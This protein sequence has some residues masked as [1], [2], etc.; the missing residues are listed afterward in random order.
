MTI[1]SWNI[2]RV[3]FTVA[4]T[5]ALQSQTSRADENG[6]SLWLPGQFGSLAA[7]PVAP[8]W[9]LGMVGYH[10]SVGASGNVAAA[11][12]IQIGQ[13]PATANVNLNANLSAR[14]DLLFISP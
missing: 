6:V 1:A 4:A 10:T 12:Q 8:G 9:S 11:R 2:C 13:V 3:T 7:V 5:L 14:G